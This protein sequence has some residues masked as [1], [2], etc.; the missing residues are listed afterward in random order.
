MAPRGVS[1][2]GLYHI[3]TTGARENSVAATVT[4]TFLL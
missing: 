1:K 4:L 2:A 3:R